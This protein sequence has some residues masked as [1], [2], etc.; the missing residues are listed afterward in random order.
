MEATLIT[1]ITYVEAPAAPVATPSL[2]PVVLASGLKRGLVA[3]L[4]QLA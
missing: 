4:F 1:D 2:P 3:G